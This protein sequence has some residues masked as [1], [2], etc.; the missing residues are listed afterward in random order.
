MGVL[1]W[2]AILELISDTGKRCISKEDPQFR[3]ALD[4]SIAR[5]DAHL[6]TAGGW[7]TTQLSRFKAQ[8]G[9]RDAPEAEVCGNDDALQMYHGMHK[10]GVA[11]LEQQTSAVIANPGPPKWGDCL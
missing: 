7:N 6:T 4:Q 10:A 11:P 8:M 3:N 5:L 2:A 1:C 9:G